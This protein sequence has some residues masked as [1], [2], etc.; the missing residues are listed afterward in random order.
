MKS[1]GYI[2]YTVLAVKSCKFSFGEVVYQDEEA[3]IMNM[4]M[5]DVCNN[6]ISVAIN[7]IVERILP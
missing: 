5:P 1:L 6:V 3:G 7:M 2:D 4:L